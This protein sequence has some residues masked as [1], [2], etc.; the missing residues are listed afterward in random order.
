MSEILIGVPEFKELYGVKWDLFMVLI[1]ISLMAS[2]A[3]CY[4]LD[5]SS[6]FF[7]ASSSHNTQH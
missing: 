7:Q 3:V 5:P 6:K 4:L 1:C 2:D